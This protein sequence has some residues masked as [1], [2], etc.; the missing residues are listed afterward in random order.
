MQLRWSGCGS[1]EA[2]FPTV[3]VAFDP[4]F[5][6][7][8]L[9]AAE[10]VHDY[11]FITHEHFDHCHPPTLDRLCRGDRFRRLYVSPG[12]VH[13]A[14]PIAEVYGDAAF[15]RD[16]PITKSIPRDRVQVLYPSVTSSLNGADREFP[17]RGPRDLEGI[18]VEVAESGE[19]A[20][21]DLPTCGYL[22]TDRETSVSIFHTGDLHEPYPELEL[23]RGRVDYLVHMKTGLTEWGERR[24]DRSAAQARRPGAA[25]VLDSHA[26]PDGPALGPHSAWDMAPGRDRRQRI[27]RVDPRSSRRPNDDSP[28][29]RR[30][31]VR[32]RP[33][34]L[35]S[36]LEMELAPDMG[37][38]TVEG[39]AATRVATTGIVA[40]A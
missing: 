8:T 40:H 34:I 28:L 24:P 20:A 31:L 19:N 22:V 39:V 17:S 25:Q 9:A 32:G 18:A 2:R 10:P 27:R 29:H 11:I 23:L 36:R 3:S 14:Q 21:P 35:G 30:R 33:A 26:L 12:C 6:D 5:F 38:A 1:F 13:P 15:E 37:C 16:L 7:E 4:Y